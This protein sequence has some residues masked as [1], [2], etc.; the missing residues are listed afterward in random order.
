MTKEEALHSFWS[1]FGWRAYNEFTVPADAELPYITYEV[2]TAKMGTT[3][4]LSASLYDRTYSWRSVYDK[5]KQIAERIG[6]GITIP[7]DYGLVWIVQGEPFTN[8]A[9]DDE[10]N[11]R[12]L[13]V[14]IKAEFISAY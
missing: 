13:Q 6:S 9:S 11:I 7:Y 8:A 10:D 2:A 14:N 12:R 3:V 5:A 4:Y 1:Q